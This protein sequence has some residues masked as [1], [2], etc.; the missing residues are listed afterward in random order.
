MLKSPATIIILSPFSMNSCV[1]NCSNFSKN[2]ERLSLYGLYTEIIA[3]TLL[4]ILHSATAHSKSPTTDSFVRLVLFFATMFSHTYPAEP[5]C[6]FS[7]LHIFNTNLKP[8]IPMRPKC[9]SLFQCSVIHK[10]IQHTQ[11]HTTYFRLS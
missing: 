1:N 9:S 6:A 8:S 5:P 4:P 3:N 7:S 11:K 2:T 10:N